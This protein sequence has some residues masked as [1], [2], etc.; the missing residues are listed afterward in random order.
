MTKR[1]DNKVPCSTEVL[2]S[3]AGIDDEEPR[4]A[5]TRRRMAFGGSTLAVLPQADCVV[6]FVSPK[7]TG[8]LTVETSLIG[9][10]PDPV[11]MVDEEDRIVYATAATECLLG[12]TPTELQGRPLITIIPSRFRRGQLVGFEQGTPG[13]ERRLPG[14]PLR[15]PVL[16]SNGTEIHVE[17]RWSEARREDG[18]LLFVASFCDLARRAAPERPPAVAPDRRLSAL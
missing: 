8:R 5:V 9:A 14:R 4:P 3:G 12:W 1:P 16:R 15:L 17:V 7:I 13:G 6:E 2:I 10:L 18:G 11:I